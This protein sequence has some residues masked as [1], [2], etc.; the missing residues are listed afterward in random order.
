MKQLSDKFIMN[1]LMIL[2]VFIFLISLF[3][4]HTIGFNKGLKEFCGKK[5][6]V[7]DD[8]GLYNCMTQDEFNKESFNINF[9]FG[10]GLK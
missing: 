3:F 6:V 1:A 8:K 5:L 7:M 10:S 9:G 2:L 4:A